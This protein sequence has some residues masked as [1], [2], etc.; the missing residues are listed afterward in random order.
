MRPNS[1][2][3][4]KLFLK[5]NVQHRTL[6][7]EH[8]IMMSL[9]S[10][11][12]F[13]LF[14]KIQSSRSYLCFVIFFHS[15]SDVHIF[16]DSILCLC[17]SFTIRCWTFDVR[18]SSFSGSYFKDLIRIE[19]FTRNRYTGC[20]KFIQKPGSDAMKLEVPLYL[21]VLGNADLCE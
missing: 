8:R 14:L 19:H 1:P 20:G 15:T 10:V 18:C 3:N 17:L 4:I 2:R 12:Y 11:I 6:N 5:M 9:R 16:R 7:V 21:S 13:Y